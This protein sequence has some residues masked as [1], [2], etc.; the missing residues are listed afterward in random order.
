MR[1]IED[2][3]LLRLSSRAIDITLIAIVFLAI[4]AFSPD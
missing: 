1:H 3:A 4:A 2:A